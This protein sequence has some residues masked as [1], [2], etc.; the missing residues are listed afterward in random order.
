MKYPEHGDIIV[1]RNGK[2]WVCADSATIKKMIGNDPDVHYKDDAIKAYD[3]SLSPYSF[4][5]WSCLDD[6]SGGDYAIEQ[7]IDKQVRV[8]SRIARLLACH[9]LP[10]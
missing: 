10:G 6:A 9:A 4:M 7:V 2:R 5:T 3:E 1:T 8:R